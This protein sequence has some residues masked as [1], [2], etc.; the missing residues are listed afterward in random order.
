VIRGDKLDPATFTPE[1]FERFAWRFGVDTVVI[2]PAQFLERAIPRDRPWNRLVECP[3]PSMVRVGDVP[4]KTN[5]GSNVVIFDFQ[6]PSSH[7]E[8]SLDVPISYTNGS[9]QLEL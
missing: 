8:S 2:E 9:L 6:N 3:S 4:T 5:N 1:E 7:P